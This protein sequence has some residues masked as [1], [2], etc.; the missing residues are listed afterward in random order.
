MSSRLL[1]ETIEEIEN[2]LRNG[3]SQRDIMSIYHVGHST[4]QMIA[5]KSDI[6]ASY[7]RKVK[8]LTQKEIDFAVN[9]RNT[10]HVGYH[11]TA[12]AARA[13]GIKTTDRRM[14]RVFI[15]ENL[16]CFKAEKKDEKKHTH[17]YYA[18]YAGQLWHTDLHYLDKVDEV[19]RYLIAFIDDCTRYI[20][21]WEVI[22]AKTSL[23][24]AQALIHALV[25]T[26][27]PMMITIDNGGE[28]IG[29]E[30]QR[31]MTEQSIEHFRTH[32][33]TPEENGKVERFWLTLERARNEG[34]QLDNQ[35]IQDIINEYN[36]VWEHS[37]LRKQLGKSSTPLNAWNTLVHYDGQDDATIV[38]LQ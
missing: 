16:Y 5:Q 1:K 14:Q 11:R 21:H 35:Y 20:V 34:R 26:K 3:V 17:L 13:R 15:K 12:Q 23:A 33:Y 9:Y 30:F 27:K 32:P 31:V 18:K 24:S 4:I 8:D 38:Y 10:F 37:S 36:N 25:K 7:G 6:I 29:K 19:Q 22:D 28:F 2:E